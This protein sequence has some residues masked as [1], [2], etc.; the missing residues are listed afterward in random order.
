MLRGKG[1]LI[2]LEIFNR[3]KILKK[4]KLLIKMKII[5]SIGNFFNKLPFQDEKQLFKKLIILL[6]ERKFF[7]EK[8]NC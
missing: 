3:K 4:W 1:H 2:K 8:K 7:N 5:E 6:M